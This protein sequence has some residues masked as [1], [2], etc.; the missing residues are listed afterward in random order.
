MEV[1]KVVECVGK[2][3]LFYIFLFIVEVLGKLKNR[4]DRKLINIDKEKILF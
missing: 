2:F 1:L 4:D 3:F